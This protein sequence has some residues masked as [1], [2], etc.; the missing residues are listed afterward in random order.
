MLFQWK[1]AVMRKADLQN[2][3]SGSERL[4]SRSKWCPDSAKPVAILLT[5][6]LNEPEIVIIKNGPKWRFMKMPKQFIFV[7]PKLGETL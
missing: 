4:H 6:H 5:I 3:I 1:G 2:P 7:T